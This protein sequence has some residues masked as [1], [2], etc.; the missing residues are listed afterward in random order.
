VPDDGR[1]P[2]PARAFRRQSGLRF[3]IVRADET[4]LLL[5]ARRLN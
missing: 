5:A 1:K 2:N 3:A 4:I